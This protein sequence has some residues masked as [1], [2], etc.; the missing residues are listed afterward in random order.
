MRH[1]FWLLIV[2]AGTG[3]AQW[4]RF[5][6]GRACPPLG[7]STCLYPKRLFPNWRRRRSR[8]PDAHP[9]CEPRA[10]TVVRVPVPLRHQRSAQEGSER[11]HF[12]ACRNR[13]SAVSDPLIRRTS[14]RL[15]VDFADF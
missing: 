4:R 6:E 8:R 12:A 5:G 9:G 7:S 15:L 3:G 11:P 2:L 10:R 13:L 1:T 14:L